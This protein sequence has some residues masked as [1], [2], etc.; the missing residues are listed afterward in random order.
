M[1]LLQKQPAES[2]VLLRVS[3]ASR[4]LA[5]STRQMRDL[6]KEGLFSPIRLGAWVRYSRQALEAWIMAQQQSTRTV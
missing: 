2:P 1:E 6:T 3:E 4:M 5:I